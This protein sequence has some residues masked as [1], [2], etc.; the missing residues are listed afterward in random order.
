MNVLCPNCNSSHVSNSTI[1]RRT[2]AVIGSLGGAITGYRLGLPLGSVGALSGGFI[3]LV[4][5]A[6]SGCEAGFILGRVIDNR[7]LNNFQCNNCLSPL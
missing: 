5:G 2:G 7:I 6:I 1:G 4:C 3:G